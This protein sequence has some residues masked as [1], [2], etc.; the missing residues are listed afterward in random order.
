M[1]A[2]DR[3]SAVLVTHNSAAVIADSLAALPAAAQTIV[4]D[5][6]STDATVELV[7]AHGA[8]LIQSETNLGF[9]NACNLG[10]GDAD[11]EF[12]FFVNPDAVVQADA[13]ESLVAAA[14]A[15]TQAAVLCPRILRP[16]GRQ[17]FRARSH[18]FPETQ[19]L[20]RV[21]PTEDQPIKVLSGAAFL[22]R[23]QVFEDLR[24]F[25]RHIFLYA[26]DDDLGLRINQAGWEMRYVHDAVVVHQGNTS[27][28]PSEALDAAKAYHEMRSRWYTAK[29]HSVPFSRFGQVLQ[30]A[31]NWG[32]AMLTFNKKAQ[33]KH[34]ARLKA[35]LEEA[36]G[37]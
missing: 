23:R 28:A 2:A 35:L 15:H 4:V 32:F 10:A 5:N 31:V 1:D 26:E 37:V 6:A 36:P 30:S 34:G 11:R 12:L 16:D 27:S 24:G 13:L 3:V 17:F 20:K 8:H 29:K 7:Q 33:T 9:G 22:C 19:N 14:D 18:L 21:A 25:D